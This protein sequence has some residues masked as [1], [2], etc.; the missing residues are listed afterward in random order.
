[1]MILKVKP[2][3]VSKILIKPVEAKSTP[4]A[5]ISSEE[6]QQMTAAAPIDERDIRAFSVIVEQ[7]S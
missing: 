6:V 5:T 4:T 7:Q 3:K 1:M 2:T